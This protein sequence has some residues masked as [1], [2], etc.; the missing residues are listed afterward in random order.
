[1][2]KIQVNLT[3]EETIHVVDGKLQ[4][5]PGEIGEWYGDEITRELE[6]SDL[7]GDISE[8]PK[9]EYKLI[10]SLEKIQD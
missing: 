5:T 9:G 2:L 8:L 6:L 7:I 3:K 10:I 4:N 1:M